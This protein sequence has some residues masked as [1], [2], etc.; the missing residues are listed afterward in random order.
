MGYL[1]QVTR[2]SLLATIFALTSTTGFAGRQMG[3]R[4]QIL[5]SRLADEYTTTLRDLLIQLKNKHKVNILFEDKLVNRP[6]RSAQ[7]SGNATL[8]QDLTRILQPYNLGFKKSWRRGIR[9]NQE[10]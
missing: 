1:L 5:N 8:E 9:Y 3:L 10:P 4:P 6:A 7:L 2:N